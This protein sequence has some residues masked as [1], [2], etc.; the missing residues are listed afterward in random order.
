VKWLVTALLV[1]GIVIFIGLG[2]MVCCAAIGGAKLAK[3]KLRE[4]E[5]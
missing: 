3:E 5:W 2:S 1:C 4:G